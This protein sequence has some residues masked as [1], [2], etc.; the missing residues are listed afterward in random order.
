MNPLPVLFVSHGAPDLPLRTGAVTAFLKQLGQNLPQPQAILAVSAHWS[1]STPTVSHATHPQTIHDFWG[2]PA[3]L[4]Q[5]T[6]PA[7]GAPDLANRVVQLLNQEGMPST[8][9]PNRGLDHGAWVPLLLTYPKANIPVTQLSIQADATP[10]HHLQLGKA[11][12]PLRHEGVLIL[13]SGGATHNLR[14]FGTTYDATPPDWVTTFDNWLADAIATGDTDAL[15]NYR[16]CAPYAAKNHP[17]E[18]HLLP[19]FVA[20]GAAGKNSQGTSLHRSY[21]YSAFSMAAY[22]FN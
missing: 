20:I 17:T 1:T 10:T 3:P 7:P 5:L 22:A 18:E 9:H 12:E 8:T 21:T 19:L 6:Y 14:E 2:F 11:L 13:A 4:Y 15:L 16:Q